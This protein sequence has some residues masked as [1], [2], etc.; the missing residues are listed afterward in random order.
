M[1]DQVLIAQ[2]SWW[3]KNI[4]F[5]IIL[6]LVL[7]I[8]FRP[9]GCG[10]PLPWEKT[11]DTTT[12]VIYEPQPPV[13]IPVYAPQ[14]SGSTSYPVL[15]PP[16]YQPSQDLARLTEQ[17]NQL[18]RDF[19]ASKTYRDSIQLKD[20][21]GNRVGVVNLEDVVS[22]NEIKSRKPDYQLTLPHTYTTITVKD[23]PRTQLFYGAGV[24]GNTIAPVNGLYGSLALKNKK[25]RIFTLQAGGQ[26]YNGK[27]V[28]QF[29]LSSYWKIGKK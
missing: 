11:R 18:V 6:V 5:L 10:N 22:E 28:P 14:Q 24:T 20:S 23:P 8:L 27:I 2:Q 16:S 15:I 12:K 1:A 25:D 13:Y 7:F 19:L 26:I 29:G 4:V 9:S 3:K 17:Y 21:S